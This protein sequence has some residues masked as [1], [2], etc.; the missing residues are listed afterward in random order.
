MW[1]I[2][3]R[4]RVGSRSSVHA[5]KPALGPA[6]WPG[7]AQQNRPGLLSRMCSEHPPL[8]GT[9]SFGSTCPVLP[10]VARSPVDTGDC[11]EQE[12]G[13]PRSAVKMQSW[14]G[15]GTNLLKPLSH[16]HISLTF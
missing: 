13:G 15:R 1:C 4:W 12:G 3:S 5:E 9:C 10:A 8:D 6:L 7:G 14:K 11:A 16:T 2:G